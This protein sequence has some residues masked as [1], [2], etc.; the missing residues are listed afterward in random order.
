MFQSILM[1]KMNELSGVKTDEDYLK[2]PGFFTGYNGLD[3][4]SSCLELGMNGYPIINGGVFPRLT[5]VIGGSAVGKTSLQVQCLGAAVDRLHRIY[6]PGYSE[7]FFDDSENNSSPKRIMDLTGWTDAEFLS[8]CTFSQKQKSLLDYAN[9]IMT[10]VDLKRK[11]RKDF[12][13][14]SGIKD[15]DGREV[16]FLAP[17]FFLVDSLP[18]INPNGIEQLISH[19]KAG[20][21]KE[22]ER[23]GTNMDGATD[24]K[25]WTVFIR[26]IKPFLDEGNINFTVIN[27]K[28]PGIQTDMYSMPEKVLPFLKPGEKPK[29]GSELIYQSY[30]ILDLQSKEK[31]N[32]F[33][34]V[35]GSDVDGFAVKAT[36]VKNKNN[37]EG[38]GFQMVFD[39]AKGYLPEMGDFEYLFDK[40]Y[41][42]SGSPASMYLDILP[43]VHFTRKN[44]YNTC[45]EHPILAR[46]LSFT[47]KIRMGSEMLFKSPAPNL[48]NIAECRNIN[49]RAG[50]ICAFTESYPRYTDLGID[51]SDDLKRLELDNRKYFLVD[52]DHNFNNSIPTSADME[53]SMRDEDTGVTYAGFTGNGLTP[54]DDL[55]DAIMD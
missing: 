5:N 24:A 37:V 20:D 41:G 6:G 3:F 10:I 14:P 32:E 55:T 33:N 12:L 52:F 43:E 53:L 42:F 50:L 16:M 40:K 26:K 36:Y 2:L 1:S 47:T 27:H 54:Y 46:A 21:Y 48:A 23:L 29:G 13:L 34:P 30:M 15:V 4:Y 49:E 44:L 38:V 39:K 28:V 35:Y 17:T 19:D 11:Y 25:A 45:H 9:K 22:L 31:Y 7:L 8:K 51:L 18:S